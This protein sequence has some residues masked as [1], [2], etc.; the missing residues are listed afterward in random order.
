MNILIT[1]GATWV[2]IDSVRVITNIFSGRTGLFLA[3]LFASAGNSVTLLINPHCIGYRRVNGII[4]VYYR[5]FEEFELLIAE[6]LKNNRYDVIIHN[7][8]VSDYKLTNSFGGKISSGQ[9]KLKLCLVPTEKIIKK[10]RTMAKKSLLI[11]FKLE[12]SRS[13]LI[14]SAYES[15]RKNDSDLVVANYLEDVRSGYKGLLISKDKEVIA[16]NSKRDLFMKLERKIV[17]V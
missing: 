7:A 15:L 1:A 12:A 14:N 3:K 11:Q 17:S 13:K 16:V 6:M 8:A 4:T 2:R 5:Y 10:I 9:K